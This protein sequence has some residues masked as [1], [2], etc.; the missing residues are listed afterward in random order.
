MT[1][2]LYY[3]D[4]DIHEATAK[5]IAVELQKSLPIVIDA[6]TDERHRKIGIGDSP[7]V[8]CGGTHVKNTKHI[9]NFSIRKIKLKKG[10]LSIG[11]DCEYA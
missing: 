10:Q 6:N 5:V 11:Y 2:R 4:T 7:P 3:T 8:G 1:T 9:S